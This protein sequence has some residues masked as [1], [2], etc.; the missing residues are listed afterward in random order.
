[1][2]DRLCGNRVP[3]KCLRYVHYT[4]NVTLQMNKL[5]RALLEFSHMSRID[6]HRNSVDL[7]LLAQEVSLKAAEP[8]R[9]VELR[10]EEGIVAECDP[11]LMRIVLN[12]LIGNSWKYTAISDKA[13][14]EFGV[15]TIGDTKVYFVRDNGLGFGMEDADK[16]FVPFR[17]LPGAEQATKEFGIGLATVERV[18]RRHGGGRVFR[19]TLPTA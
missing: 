4:C 3:E 6:L 14:V 7:S 15:E 1:M 17:R 13:V 18:I 10:N 19:F 9:D 11:N 8:Q 12:N 16:L 5:I 2:I